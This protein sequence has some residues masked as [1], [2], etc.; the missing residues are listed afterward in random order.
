MMKQFV[1]N[2][3]NIKKMSEILGRY[4]ADR[5]KSAAVPLLDIAQRQNSGYL[6]QEIIEYVASILEM[7]TY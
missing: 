2:K 4:P 3:D 5:K 7:P 1:F 6:S